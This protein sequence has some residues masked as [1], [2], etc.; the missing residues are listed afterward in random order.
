MLLIES[1]VSF[2]ILVISLIV[3]AMASSM[4]MVAGFAIWIAFPIS[5]IFS[6]ITRRS[7]QNSTMWWSAGIWVFAAFAASWFILRDYG[8]VSQ[9][10]AIANFMAEKNNEQFSPL[11]ACLQQPVRAVM[12]FLGFLGASAGGGVDQL[13]G[14]T[15][16]HEGIAISFG[17]L[18]VVAYAGIVIWLVAAKRSKQLLSRLNPWLVIGAVEMI[19]A[20]LTTVG[21]IGGYGIERALSPHYGH[22]GLQFLF[23]IGVGCFLTWN[24]IIEA[25]ET[26]NDMGLIR[27]RCI[28]YGGRVLV[29]FGCLLF[30]LQMFSQRTSFS[31]IVRHSEQLRYER[32]SAYFAHAISEEDLPDMLKRTGFER[33][34]FYSDRGVFNVASSQKIEL[35]KK[36]AKPIRWAGV[37]DWKSF[38]QV[39]KL[40]HQGITRIDGYFADDVT[41]LFDDF[42]SVILELKCLDGATRSLVLPARRK[43]STWSGLP[44][45]LQHINFTEGGGVFKFHLAVSNTRFAGSI[46]SKA[47]V[48]KVDDSRLDLAF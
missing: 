42:R 18:G 45:S 6:G 1:K 32:S 34:E 10:D 35:M 17:L 39:S 26:C 47:F 7:L 38:T 27:K 25:S 29:F 40:D 14:G 3:L 16:W 9:F 28:R 21:R 31:E 5:V 44:V 8:S 12:F 33:L 20:A 36:S 24:D 41:S 37:S 11:V 19:Q 15:Y 43:K 4:T 13:L 22:V 48:I 2:N 46:I 23:A 30:A